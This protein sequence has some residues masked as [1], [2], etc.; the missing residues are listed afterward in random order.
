MPTWAFLARRLRHRSEQNSRRLET[1]RP[2]RHSFIGRS[3]SRH[4]GFTA[5]NVCPC[6]PASSSSFP[7]YSR[8]QS[9]EQHR[10]PLLSKTLSQ[11]LHATRNPEVPSGRS[12]LGAILSY[13]GK[14]ASNASRQRL[15]QNRPLVRRND[16]PHAKH[17]CVST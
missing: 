9:A 5:P 10:N 1:R 17:C 14:P 12:N 13:G 8:S 2:S 15:E 11:F 7:R 16:R 3:H 4:R 6:S